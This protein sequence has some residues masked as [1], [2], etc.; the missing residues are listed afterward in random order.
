MVS[1]LVFQ[2]FIALMCSQI[3]SAVKTEKEITITEAIYRNEGSKDPLFVL[4]KQWIFFQSEYSELSN[5]NVYS[6]DSATGDRSCA[7]SIFSSNIL[8]IFRE[9][10][11][12]GDI[13]FFSLSAVSKAI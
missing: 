11:D 13:I 6:D 3:S 1:K 9:I 8:F 12:H 5:Q 2:N 7:M 4:K 10:I